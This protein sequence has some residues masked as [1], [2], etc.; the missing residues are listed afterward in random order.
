MIHRPKTT[1][2]YC[3]KNPIDRNK[4]FYVG[5][6][7]Q[8]LNV[9]LLGHIH[10][11]SNSYIAVVLKSIRD[12]GKNPAIKQLEVC[13]GYLKPMQRERYWDF[14]YRKRGCKLYDFG[15]SRKKVSPTDR[16]YW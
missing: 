10:K 1:I 13:E 4:V 8:S 2:I 11:P 14:Y 16:V 5:R 9:R 7:R 15:F 3:L 6:T 12:A